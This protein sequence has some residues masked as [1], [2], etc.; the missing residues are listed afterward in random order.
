MT[1]STIINN[2]AD[3]FEDLFGKIEKVKE[4]SIYEVCLSACLL[5]LV[6][7]LAVSSHGWAWP[8]RT[9]TPLMQGAL[10]EDVLSAVEADPIWT[11]YEYVESFSIS[12][13][14]PEGPSC[15]IGLRQ[16]KY[17]DAPL[18]IYLVL[19][20]SHL[21]NRVDH[22]IQL[23]P[24]PAPPGYENVNMDAP[25]DDF[26][27]DN[28]DDYLAGLAKARGT[29]VV[30]PSAPAEPAGS[31]GGTASVEMAEPQRF[32]W[33]AVLLGFLIIILAPFFLVRYA[34]RK[35]PPTIG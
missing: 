34:S 35:V 13:R 19:S 29:E 17:V 31:Y 26:G 8:S 16:S 12:W 21:R 5:V 7:E 23:E 1:Q 22:P 28:L 11:D 4:E 25:P 24:I 32:P 9:P 3:T 30:A 10:L 6:M 20:W 33:L 14:L 2:I 18:R 27:P 15:A